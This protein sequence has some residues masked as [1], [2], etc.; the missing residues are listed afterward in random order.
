MTAIGIVSILGF[1]SLTFFCVSLYLFRK[2][3]IKTWSDF[4]NVFS[5]KRRTK[6]IFISNSWAI[7]GGWHVNATF[8]DL[9]IFGV[10]VKNLHTYYISYRGEFST[11]K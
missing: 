6:R 8:V 9:L 4:K 2:Y 3:N 11:I 10:K 1:G 7:G 5:V